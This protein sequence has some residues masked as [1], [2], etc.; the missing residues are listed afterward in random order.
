MLSAGG[1]ATPGRPEAYATDYLENATSRRVHPQLPLRRRTT[2][3][4]T[5]RSGFLYNALATTAKN[6]P[7]TTASSSKPG[8]PA[9]RSG[10]DLYAD[11]LT[12]SAKV[13]VGRAPGPRSKPC[14]PHF[15]P[16]L[17]RLP[18][19][20]YP[21]STAP[22]RFLKEFQR[23]QEQQ[24]ALANFDRDAPAERP[25]FEGPSLTCRPR[26]PRWPTTTWRSAGSSRRS[27][28][29]KFWPETAIFVVEDD[30]QA[31]LDHV[32]GHPPLAQVISP[33]TRRRWVEAIASTRKSA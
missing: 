30:P 12:G 33:Y 32:D 2:P 11:Y 29:S 4:P 25:H 19:P 17:H 16:Q 24:G 1:R 31:G 8:S 22:A 7:Q 26:A 5:R 14:G 6:L 9:R 20:P 27:R 3:W 10:A 15:C 23:A 21:T 28:G 18:P 13:Q